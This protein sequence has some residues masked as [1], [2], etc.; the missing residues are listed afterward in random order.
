MF[1]H[2]RCAESNFYTSADSTMAARIYKP[3]MLA[4]LLFVS[5]PIHAQAVK[6]SGIAADD[7]AAIVRLAEA[8]DEAWNQKDA[9]ALSRLFT[10]DAHNWMVGSEMNLRDREEIAA[11][12]TANFEQRGPGLRHRTVVK[13]LQ[14]VASGVV[15][16]DGEV[17]VERVAE[18]QAPVVLRRFTMSSV[19]VNGPEGWRLRIDRVHLQP[20][21]APAAAGQR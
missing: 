1:P 15:V 21:P 12:F 10:E 20:T 5:A 11:F 2:P 4:A 13:E 14:L 19:A 18:G 7:V 6:T 16:A 8:G 9:V 17:F 3:L